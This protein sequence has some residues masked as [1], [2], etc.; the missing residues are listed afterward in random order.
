[1]RAKVCVGIPY[2]HRTATRK[3]CCTSTYYDLDTSLPLLCRSLKKREFDQKAECG[4]MRN[5]LLCAGALSLICAAWGG[6]AAAAAL[7]VTT[8]A[9]MTALTAALLVPGSGLTLTSS[10]LTR[11]NARRQGT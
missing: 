1:M 2:S 7:S 4:P 9:D 6:R 5:Q 8:T 3:F 10:E 11:G